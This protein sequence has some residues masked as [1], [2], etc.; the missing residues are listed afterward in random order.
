[1][2]KTDLEDVS[3]DSFGAS[4]LEETEALHD[5]EELEPAKKEDEEGEDEEGEDELLVSFGDE[6]EVAEDPEE[7][8]FKEAPKWV[9]ELRKANREQARRIKELEA[10]AQKP[11]E[12]QKIKLGEKPTLE[13]CDFDA[14]EF[15]KQLATWYET[16]AKVDKQEADEKMKKDAETR[17][18]KQMI[19][20]FEQKKKAL[21]VK[22]YADAEAT[23]ADLASQ[24]QLGIIVQGAENPALL[25]YALGKNPKKAK[26][27]FAITDYVKFSFAVSKLEAT[28]R[29]T[30]RKPETK[31]EQT[32]RST[33]A[34]VS[35]DRTLERLR[36]E[37]ERTGDY[38]KVREYKQKLAKGAK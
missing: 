18:W 29:S 35:S 9:R 6:L 15:D 36:S 11:V 38:T 1:M 23:V 31:P 5:S 37:A 12:A 22:D 21:K 10:A 8:K 20:S 17:A 14:E 30:E 16:K 19:D 27:L 25:V 33:T 24:T 34:T 3:T 7:K 28:L 2:E 13:A 26:E 32:R 4:E